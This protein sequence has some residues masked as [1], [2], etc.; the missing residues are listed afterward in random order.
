L[1]VQRVRV[2]HHPWGSHL[3]LCRPERRNALDPQTVA[4]LHE[5]VTADGTGP[6]LL[7]AHGP[8]FCAGG[9]L[10]VLQEA[11]AGGDLV[12][13]L[14]TNAAAFA[15]LIEAI[16]DCP[17]PVVAVLDGPAV[18][19]GASLAL[20]CDMRV[21]TPRARL[22]FNW[23]RYG[24][25]PDGHAKPLLAW[26]VGRDRAEALLADAAELTTESELAPRLFTG[27]VAKRPDRLSLLTT[28]QAGRD[29][30][31]AAIARAAADGG[32]SERL[33]VLYKIDR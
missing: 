6:I 21:A 17:R 32:T 27:I 16:V 25:P 26:A 13:V 28:M 1:T 22:V 19:G 24:L 30:E 4:E 33:A 9:D 7:T 12:E 15:D 29:E 31:L 18:G 5:A 3:E 10:R 20:A 8:A 14:T 23:S 11:A 2:A